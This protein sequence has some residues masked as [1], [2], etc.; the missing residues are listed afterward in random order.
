MFSWVFELPGIETLVFLAS[1]ESTEEA[2]RKILARF[3]QVP[4]M[5][6][7]RMELMEAA[8]RAAPP[9]PIDSEGDV[10]VL[11]ASVSLTPR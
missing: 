2:A 11:T 4:V 3:A 8:L 10:C 6:A 5:N 1:A 9:R 7:H